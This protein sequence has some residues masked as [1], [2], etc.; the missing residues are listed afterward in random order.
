MSGVRLYL[1]GTP[2]IEFEGQPVKI[3]RRKALAL[4]AYLALT[5][6]PQSRDHVAGLLWSD[7]D[8]DHARSALRSTLRA[9]TTPISAAWIDADRANV[10]IKSDAA[11]VDVTAFTDLLAAS[12]AHPHDP[13]ALCADCVEMYK[14]AIA[15]YRADLMTGFHLPDCPEYDE[16]LLIQR[17]GLCRELAALHHRL[18]DHYAAQ[19]QLEQAIRHAQ[20]WL[21]MD[22]LNE[23]AHRQLMRLYAADGQ[24]SEAIRQYQ[25]CVELL[26]AELATPPEK[27]TTQLYQSVLSG[28]TT[29]EMPAEPA[30]ASV[31][32]IMPPLPALVVGRAEAM[33]EI[34]R[35]FGIEGGEI[36]RV[37]VIQGLPGVGK[38]TTVATLAH[39]SAVSRQF[40]DGVLWTSLGETPDIRL[41]LASWV[42][43][44][45]LGGNE[46]VQ[47]A[48]ET[49]A[50]LA[51]ALRDKRVL[52]I[53][54]DVWQKEHAAPFRVGGQS[55][56]L[57]MTTRLND[58]ASALA[59]TAADVYRLT[60]LDTASSLE[61]LSM[62]TPE[63][64]NDYPEQA[65]ALVRDLEGLP[66]AIHVAGRLL[67]AESR[68]GW[69]VVELLDELR[70]GARLLE[71]QL[72]GDIIGVQRDASP[73]V[74]ALLKRSTDL[75]DADLRARFA[76][77]GL[78]VP[79]PATFD[80]AA[81]AALWNVNDP[82][83]FARALVNRGLLEPVSGGRFQMH[84]LLVLHAR[85]L[86]EPQ[87][88]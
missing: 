42:K 36:R 48:Q 41:E 16:W 11:W 81:M 32:G 21:A 84:A 18:S 79:K 34:K 61:L 10:A 12:A 82:R 38:S 60:V 78:F 37:T 49:S 14:Q 3:A 53:V 7:Q 62:L 51:A 13:D 24:R 45:R 35:R 54:D 39:D 73:T 65:A 20:R 43:A 8:D 87:A 2:R 44:L 57:I 33:T 70:G 50:Q 9:L 46:R 26:E 29:A 31:S 1:L 68:L 77:L 69:G 67:H 85:T 86:L 74:A 72:P 30:L 66:L 80:L 28:G 55:C 58:V 63:T 59:P 17:E 56:A 52:L 88:E 40:P 25:Q 64:V 19:G 71:A 15:L 27:E 75:L 76:L 23:P 6:Q 4:A 83:P 47:K 22:A 5:G